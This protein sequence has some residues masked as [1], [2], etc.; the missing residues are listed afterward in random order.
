MCV[1]TNKSHVFWQMDNN[2]TLDEMSDNGSAILT[3]SDETITVPTIHH[4]PKIFL[5]TP[6]AQGIAGVFA[7]AAMIITCWQVKLCN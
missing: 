1:T 2:D 4:V 7:F 5:Q 6:A 3:S